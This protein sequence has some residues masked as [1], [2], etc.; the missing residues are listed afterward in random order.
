MELSTKLKNAR[1]ERKVTQKTLAE[2]LG[3]SRATVSSWEK[4][5]STPSVL[6]LLEYKKLFGL[7]G[8]YFDG[9]GEDT[10][11]FD[12][13]RLNQKGRLVLRD[14]YNSLIKNKEYAKKP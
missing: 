9:E 14:F 10:V 5:R 12:V 2:S 1:I 11:S 6:Y 13:S 4:G 8:N 7:K 3:V